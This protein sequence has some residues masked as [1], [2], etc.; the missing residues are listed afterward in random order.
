MR[1]KEFFKKIKSSTEYFEVRK[2]YQDIIE[3]LTKCLGDEQKHIL[4]DL[5][6][7]VGELEWE[8]AYT[9]YKEGLKYGMLTVLKVLD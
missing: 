6:L 8:F 3:K 5:I 7:I 4:E 1:T 9:R 2:K